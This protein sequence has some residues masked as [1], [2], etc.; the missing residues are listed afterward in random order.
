[1]LIDASDIDVKVRLDL[2]EVPRRMMDAVLRG[3]CEQYVGCFA[4]DGVWDPQPLFRVSNGRDEIRAAFTEAWNS[5][6]WAFQGQFHTVISEFSGAR[7]Q[8]RTYLYELGTAKGDT[9]PPPIGIGLY[10]DNLAQIDGKWYVT[11]HDLTP[12]YFGSSDYSKPIFQE[13]PC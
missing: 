6:S 9:N 8:M 2:Y 13:L 12:I 11:R 7:A 10:T 3:D 5:M 4:E 1:M